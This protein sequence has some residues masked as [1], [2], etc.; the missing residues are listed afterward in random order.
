MMEDVALSRT[1]GE[2]VGR[3]FHELLESTRGR[4]PRRRGRS[5][6]SRA[7]AASRRSSPRAGATIEGDMV[8]V[9][10]GVR[11]DTMLAAA[12]RARGRRRD[13]LRLEARDLG[14]GDLRRRR[15]LLVRQ[16][17]PRPAAAGRALGRGAAA[18]PA[19]RPRRCSAT[20]EPYERGALL[21]QR[22]RRLGEPRVRRA[23]RRA[24]TRWS[25][26]ATA[27]RASS[28]PGTSKD[29]KVGGALS[30]ERSEDLGHARR[31]D[32][33]GR[34]RVGARAERARGRGHRPRVDRR[35]RLTG[36][37][38]LTGVASRQRCGLV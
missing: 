5:R 26:A 8:V 10:A 15:R 18:G 14:R 21:L 6:R 11:P 17:G 33:D 29:G 12:R 20:R 38:G 1:F 36:P 34:G 3:C 2:E 13:R 30:V 31:A 19:R 16:R 27:T 9:G 28:A 7:T 22:P 37:L 24:G 32:R 23:G 25:G 35:A 4:V